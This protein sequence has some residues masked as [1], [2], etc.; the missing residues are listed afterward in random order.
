MRREQRG[1]ERFTIHL[2]IVHGPREFG[3][4]LVLQYRRRRTERWDW[5]KTQG[6]NTHARYELL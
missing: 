6:R 2:Q 3:V 5:T 4:K 1:E